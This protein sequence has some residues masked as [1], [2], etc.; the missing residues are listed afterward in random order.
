MDFFFGTPT[1]GYPYGE[2]NN[3]DRVRNGWDQDVFPF[4]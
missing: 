1:G 4:Y 2:T 3:R